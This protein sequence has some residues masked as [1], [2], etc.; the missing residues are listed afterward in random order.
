MEIPI[1]NRIS[2]IS[3]VFRD[4]NDIQLEKEDVARMQNLEHI[5]ASKRNEKFVDES[6]VRAVGDV[7]PPCRLASVDKI[8]NQINVKVNPGSMFACASR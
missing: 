4:L 8:K 6:D 1:F 2:E 7:V 3:Y 5:S